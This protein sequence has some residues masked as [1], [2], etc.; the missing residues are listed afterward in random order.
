MMTNT[1]S[2]SIQT[3]Q[4]YVNGRWIDSTTTQWLEVENPSTGEVIG[5]VPISTAAEA[6]DAIDA[7][8]QAFQQWREVPATTRVQPLF[9]LT[10]KLKAHE[11]S[12]AR[13]VSLENGKSLPDARA[14][15]KRAVENCEVACGMPVLQQGDTLIGAASGIDGQVLRLPRGVYTMIAPFNFPAMVPFWFLPYAL[16]TG[17][18]YVVKPSERVPLTMSYLAQLIADSDLPPGVFNLVNGSVDVATAFMDNPKTAGVSFVG[19]SRVAALVAQRCAANNKRF[20]AMG[21]AKNHL[22]VMP[23]AQLDQV[24]R[25]MI[26]SCYGCAGQRCMASSAVVAVGDDTYRRVCAAF[27]EASKQVKVGDPLNPALANES[28]LMG[29]VISA[30]AKQFILGM[31]E[32]GIAEGATLAHDGRNAKVIGDHRGHFIGPVVF[33]DV[34]PGM[35]IHKTEIFGPVAIILKARSFDEAVNIINEHQYGNGASIYT[36]SGYWA[37]RFKLEAQ[38][39]MIGINVGIPAPV[40]PLPFGG[41]KSSQFSAVKTQGRSTIHFFTEEKIVT[42]RFWA[43]DE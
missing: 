16:A 8:H 1:L 35:A 26:T 39:G 30:K 38:C 11:E 29:P 5:S 36:Q 24:I 4:N 28:M 41:M 20:Q 19:T 12:I 9:E 21:G 6:S 15:V 33:T 43:G 42:E 32:Q 23:D 17:N 13:L 27:T 34:K 31:I 40:A 3:L 14:E 22:V 25:N 37:R 2:T 7:A 18:T 10:Q